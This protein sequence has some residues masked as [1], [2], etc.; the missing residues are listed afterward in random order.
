M[1][2]RSLNEFLGRGRAKL[3][4]RGPYALVLLEDRELVDE[5]ISHCKSQGFREVLVFGTAELLPQEDEGLHL[6]EQ[7]MHVGAALTK[8]VNAIIR[9]F[10]G[11]WMHYCFNAEFLFFPF[12]E[13]RNIREMLA[14]HTEERRDAVLSYVVDLYSTDLGKHP[15]GIS[16]EGAHFDCEGHYALE[17]R[18]AEGQL[19]LEQLDFYGGLRWRF[20]EHIPLERRRIDRI[21]LF[22]AARGLELRENHTFNIEEYNTYTCPWHNNITTALCS[23]RTA[24]ALLSNPQ[25]MNEIGHFW[26]KHSEPFKWDS[27]QLMEL[28]LM[29]PGQWF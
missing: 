24:K 16:V 2:Y 26:W 15:N 21:S 19:L 7:N 13:T 12:C 14:F 10:P 27:I 4:P 1:R 25:S 9:A 22:R 20:E 17:R 3:D 23:F 8:I 11:I 29:E 28:G 5:T 6:I 18:D